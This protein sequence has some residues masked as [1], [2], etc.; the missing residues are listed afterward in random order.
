[1]KRII[2]ILLIISLLTPSYY[3]LAANTKSTELSGSGQYW[4]D[5]SSTDFDFGTGVICFLFGRS[6]INI[7]SDNALYTGVAL[8]LMSIYL[9][10]KFFNRHPFTRWW[11]YN[12]NN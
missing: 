6:M 1:M 10:S 8:I 3:L 7:G 11:N 4:R 9:L 5:T 12:G 2:V